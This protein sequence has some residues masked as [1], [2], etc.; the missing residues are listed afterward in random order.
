MQSLRE[1]TQYEIAAAPRAVCSAKFAV[2]ARNGETAKRR[3]GETAKRRNGE[4]AKR[5]N[6]R[7]GA[8]A[9]R[10][11]ET[12]VRRWEGVFAVSGKAPR[13]GWLSC[14]VERRFR[15]PRGECG[16]IALLP[17]Q[18][19]P[20]AARD[21]PITIEAPMNVNVSTD[22][23]VN[24]T[25][26]DTPA[27]ESSKGNTGAADYESLYVAAMASLEKMLQLVLGKLGQI[28]SA[29]DTDPPADTTQ[30]STSTQQTG[31]AQPAATGMTAQSASGALAAYMHEHQINTVD[32]DQLYQLAFRPAAGTPPQVSQA[33]KFMLSNPET[34]N[35]IETHDVAGSDGIAGVNDFDWAAQGGLSTASG[36]QA[37]SGADKPSAFAGGDM[38]AA[39]ALAAFMHE[40]AIGTVTPNRLYQLAFNPAAGTPP[41]VSLA[42]KFMLGNPNTFNKIE[43]HDVAGSDGIAGV[44]DLDWAAEGGLGKH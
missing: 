30:K 4:T 18:G 6:G 23:Q 37:A 36:A 25:P 29:P 31:A 9:Q 43:T 7:G 14:R 16:S 12:T 1:G 38:G 39:G 11:P 33:A 13:R 27:H 8:S 5:R 41:A 34:F 32:P 35:K 15:P 20:C 26:V 3:N 21:G 19:R 44:N 10:E 42:A 40:H 24:V 17:R 2:L 22:S 28:D